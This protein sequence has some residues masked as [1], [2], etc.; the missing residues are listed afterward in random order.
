MSLVDCC[1]S[2]AADAS[3]TVMQHTAQTKLKH[4]TNTAKTHKQTSAQAKKSMHKVQKTL[5]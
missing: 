1:T 4:C 5:K 3:S 2:Y